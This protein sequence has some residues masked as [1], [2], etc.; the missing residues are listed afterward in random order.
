MSDLTELEVMTAR[1]E[2]LREAH[3][4]ANDALRSAWQV[5]ERDGRNTN[6]PMF[7]STLRASLEASHAAAAALRAYKPPKGD[8]HE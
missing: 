8:D 1:V 3:T 5:A 7:R 4:L 2:L 6:W